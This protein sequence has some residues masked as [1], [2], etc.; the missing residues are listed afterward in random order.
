VKFHK[1]YFLPVIHQLF[2][3][4]GGVD[5]DD[6]QTEYEHFENAIDYWLK[7]NNLPKEKLVAGIPFYGWLFKSADNAE[8]AEVVACRDILN[9]FPN[10]DAH[11]KDNIGL[12]YYNDMRTIQ[13]K[14]KYIRDNNLGGIMIWELSQ[15]TDNADKG[16]LNA[17]HEMK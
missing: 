16:L 2:P 7:N 9:S 3:V 14:A 11:L 10:Q 8:G 15:D 12:L 5:G 1:N 13:D 6:F 17:I 4:R